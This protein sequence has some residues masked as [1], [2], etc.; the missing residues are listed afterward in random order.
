MHKYDVA[1]RGLPIPFSFLPSDTQFNMAQIK[2]GH[3]YNIKNVKYEDLAGAESPVD[4]APVV[5]GGQVD[6]VRALIVIKKWISAYRFQWVARKHSEN[7]WV[8]RANGAHGRLYASVGK[9]PDIGNIIKL[10]SD[11][12][13]WTLKHLGGNRYKCAWALVPI[14]SAIF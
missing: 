12:Y 9:N 13:E 11:P 10:S 8:F 7:T 1:E 2:D 4:R 6:E 5:A 14:S 3:I